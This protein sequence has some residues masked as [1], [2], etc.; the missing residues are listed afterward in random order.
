MAIGLIIYFLNMESCAFAEE[1]LACFALAPIVC[2][3]ILLISCTHA[4]ALSFF[5]AKTPHLDYSGVPNPPRGRSSMSSYDDGDGGSHREQEAV[6]AVEAYILSAPSPLGT[7]NLLINVNE[8]QDE[9]L[10]V[11]R[12]IWECPMINKIARFDDTGKPFS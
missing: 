5:Q 2:V 3:P 8:D 4:P 10:P 7:G 1:S 11:L 6:A 9:E 12:S